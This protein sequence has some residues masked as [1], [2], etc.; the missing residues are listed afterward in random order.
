LAT[1][2]TVAIPTYNRAATLRQTLTSIRALNLG[3]DLSAECIVVDN[4]SA[5]ETPAVVDELAARSPVP[6]RRVLEG[7]PGSSFARNRAVQEANGDFILF[8]DDD[9]VVEPDWAREMVAEIERRHLDAACGAVLP[10]WAAAR[11][12]WLGPRLYSK[13]AV[14]A[15]DALEGGAATETLTNYFSANAGF[16]RAA[17]LRFGKFREDLG[18]V[19][20]NPLSGEDTELF[21]RIIAAGG[22]VGFAPRAA[23]Y[24]LIGPERMTRAYFRHKSFAY[25]VGSA[26]AGGR[27]HNRIDKLA[28]NA[29]R[30]VLAAARGDAEGAFYHQLECVNF[31]GYWR[32][33]A[34]KL[35]SPRCSALKR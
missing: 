31:L 15:P 5:D 13:L 24:H 20:G 3:F 12:G 17:F 14:H 9:V 1:R 2:L 34:T 11:P 6:V 19:G 30:M 26:Y 32:G 27:S 7:Q 25:G 33:R 23:V 28:R 21:A 16:R 22:R 18:V 29:W 4:N 35:S 10:R 8:I